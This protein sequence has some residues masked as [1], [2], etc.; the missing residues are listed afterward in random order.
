M[1]ISSR[2]I[3]EENDVV[4]T[5]DHVKREILTCSWGIRR[6]CHDR[7]WENKVLWS[8]N[9]WVSPTIPKPTFIHPIFDFFCNHI[10][11]AKTKPYLGPNINVSMFSHMWGIHK[12]A[13]AAFLAQCLPSLPGLIR[14]SSGFHIMRSYKKN[15]FDFREKNR[16]SEQNSKFSSNLTS[17]S[18]RQKCAQNP[19]FDLSNRFSRKFR[20]ICFK[21]RWIDIQNPGPRIRWSKN[22]IK[23]SFTQKIWKLFA[24]IIDLHGTKKCLILEIGKFFLFIKY[25][26]QTRH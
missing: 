7:S 24:T 10:F 26:M 1:I 22:W 12:M 3:F 14:W 4:V 17:Q 19:C 2:E 18:V 13:K 16:L 11:Y 20:F 21:I 8:E 6:P 23:V 9:D 15:V 5:N 25:Q